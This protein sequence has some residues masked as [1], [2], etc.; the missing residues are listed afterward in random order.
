MTK[1]LLRHWKKLG[2]NGKRV[3]LALAGRMALGADRYGDFPARRWTQEAAEEALD[4]SV[5]LMAELVL[6][7]T[8]PRGRA[9]KPTA[10]P[11]ATRMRRGR[12]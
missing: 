4:Q 12:P 10:R 6:V 7:A 8:K 11:P 3:L 1:K 5:Y 2:P 9:R